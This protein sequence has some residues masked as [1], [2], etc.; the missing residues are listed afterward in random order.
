MDKK[1]VK[2]DMF[3]FRTMREIDKGNKKNI[4]NFCQ[5]CVCALNHATQHKPSYHYTFH[6]K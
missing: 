1:P 5:K 6:N 2:L 3:L 4:E